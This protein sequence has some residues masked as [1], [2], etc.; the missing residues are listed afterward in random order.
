MQK[1][2]IV[3]FWALIISSLA[4]VS[5]SSIDP[6]AQVLDPRVY[7][8]EFQELLPDKTPRVFC[9]SFFGFPEL[10]QKNISAGLPIV[11]AR[12]TYY[13][14]HRGKIVE[15]L[16]EGRSWYAFL[17]QRR[18]KQAP[19]R[20]PFNNAAIVGPTSYYLFRPC[21][22]RYA[23][24][25]LGTQMQSFTRDGTI[26]AN[27]L[28]GTPEQQ[29]H[30]V[31]RLYFDSGDWQAVVAWNEQLLQRG[32]VK[33]QAY[34]C[35]VFDLAQGLFWQ[36]LYAKSVAYFEQLKWYMQRD[37]TVPGYVLFNLA[38]AYLYANQLDKADSSIEQALS[39][40][41]EEHALTAK[42][43]ED[44]AS[45]FYQVRRWEK[46]LSLFE[47]CLLVKQQERQ[48]YG[49]I[50]Q[51]MGSIHY[52]KKEYDKTVGFYVSA[53]RILKEEGAPYQHLYADLTAL[54]AFAKKWDKVIYYAQAALHDPVGICA[55]QLNALVNDIAYAYEMREEIEKASEMYVQ[56][57]RQQPIHET[58]LNMLFLRQAYPERST[59][60]PQEVV[61][62]CA[63][64]LAAVPE[65]DD[66]IL[67]YKAAYFDR[68]TAARTFASTFLFGCEQKDSL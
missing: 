61:A 52:Y 53:A 7:V 57:Y 1:N 19:K 29:M 65:D 12:V 30:A 14:A 62:E 54:Y 11:I 35:A 22:E 51:R 21:D 59:Q 41:Q 60:I 46:A 58:R 4:P 44:A 8:H 26:V 37:S 42:V 48:P 43:L 36:G 2:N 16:A 3:L 13:D 6:A 24:T 39:Q 20:H 66:S 28:S 23:V 56:C 32:H 38:R 40:L 64:W 55:D 67:G 33:G 45:M 50:L 25:F 10:A 68:Y 34:E 47:R 31:S 63:R 5:C 9:K 27:I 18:R 49:H 15:S 17:N